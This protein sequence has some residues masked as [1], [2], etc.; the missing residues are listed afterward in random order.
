MEGRLIA[1]RVAVDDGA[2]LQGAVDT[3]CA[4]I[5]SQ[6]ARFRAGVKSGS[7]NEKT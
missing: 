2:Y 4:Y 5:A 7:N 1:P 3:T 6:V